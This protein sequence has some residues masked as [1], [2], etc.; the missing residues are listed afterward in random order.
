MSFVVETNEVVSI[1]LW[2]K[3]VGIE[4]SLFRTLLKILRSSTGFFLHL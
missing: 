4:L 1:Y 3:R 2:I